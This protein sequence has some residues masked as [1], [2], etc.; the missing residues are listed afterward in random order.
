A[1]THILRSKRAKPSE[2]VCAKEDP[3]R[4]IGPSDEKRERRLGARVE[5][6]EEPR[7]ADDAC[8]VARTLSRSDDSLERGDELRLLR[9]GQA[10]ACLREGRRPARRERL[11]LVAEAPRVR[12]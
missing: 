9:L 11:R 2:V 10:N 5:R 8:V 4:P 6:E 3:I 7:G 12:E 1:D